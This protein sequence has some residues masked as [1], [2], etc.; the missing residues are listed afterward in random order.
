[1]P[2]AFGGQSQQRWGDNTLTQDEYLR[3]SAYRSFRQAHQNP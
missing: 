2:S 1:M 3:D